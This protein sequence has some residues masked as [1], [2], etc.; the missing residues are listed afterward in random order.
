MVENPVKI[1]GADLTNMRQS[2]GR[3]V[4]QS[5]IDANCNRPAAAQLMKEWLSHDRRFDSFDKDRLVAKVEEVGMSGGKLDLT[6]P[7]LS[8]S[9][10]RPLYDR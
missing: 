8:G 10:R 5:Y 3:M 6:D 9:A 1:Y 7:Y 4:Q 2:L